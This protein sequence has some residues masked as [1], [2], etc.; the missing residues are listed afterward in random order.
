M[1]IN[2]NDDLYQKGLKD[3]RHLTNFQPQ[4]VDKLIGV[5]AASP[6]LDGIKAAHSELKNK[7]SQRPSTWA[8]S[9]RLKEA[10]ANKSEYPQNISKM[11]ESKEKPTQEEAL[12]Q[13]GQ[14]DGYDLAKWAPDIAKDLSQIKSDAPYLVGLRSGST[15]YELDK[16]KALYKDGFHLRPPNVESTKEDRNKN[17]FRDKI[18]Q[19]DQD[20]NKEESK[21]QNP[22]IRS[23]NSKFFDSDRLKNSI[24]NEQDKSQDKDLSNGNS[25]FF[26]SERLKN[27]L[28][29]TPK[30][31]DQDKSK[32]DPDR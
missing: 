25:K 15:E 12:Y 14:E 24:K 30:Q 19:Q 29:N 11:N 7:E 8:N 28:N 10:L 6:Y 23:N 21:E 27:S 32:D 22:E 9:N 2:N 5:K 18:R 16:N 1:E 26:D 4:I 20:K 13:K 17:P 31:P 3:G